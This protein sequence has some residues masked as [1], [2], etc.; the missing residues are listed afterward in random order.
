MEE[1][2]Y[3]LVSYELHILYAALFV[4]HEE[5][6]VQTLLRS[7]ECPFSFLKGH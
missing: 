5:E 4:L 7:Q 6:N 1:T 3:F 2:A